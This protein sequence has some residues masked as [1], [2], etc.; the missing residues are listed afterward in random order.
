[1]SKLF[2]LTLRDTPTEAGTTGHQFLLRAGLLRPLG[3]G[4]YGFTPLG[5]QTRRKIKAIARQ[6]MLAV[7]GQ[8]VNLPHVQSADLVNANLDLEKGATSLAGPAAHFRDRMQHEVILSTSQEAAILN[9][10]RGVVQS[11]RQLPL[12]LYQVWTPFRDESRAWGGLFGTRE[13]LVVDG[14]SLHADDAGLDD[15][16]PRV[17]EALGEVFERCQL[18]VLSVMAGRDGDTP[19]MHR[20]VWPS[21][22]GEETVILCDAC[23]YSA[24][25]S[26]AR[27]GKTPP[28]EEDM[29]PMQDIE[30]PECKTI[31]ELAQFLNVPESRT[32][33]ALFL[34]AYIEG[35][36]D[37]FV[38][39]VV[40]GD[41]DLNESKLKRVLNAETVGPATEAEIRHA[42]AEPGYGSPVGLEGVTVVVDD[43]IP[44]SRNLVAGANKPGYH[45]LNVNYGRDYQASSVADITL[46]QAG[47][48]CPECG[49]AL[50][51]EKG[52]ELASTLK[53][54]DRL[55]Q[56][57]D[58]T[59]LD[60]QGKAQPIV[61]G[62]YRLYADRLLAAV[63]ETHYDEHGII[64]PEAI[65][66]YHVYLMTLGKR[67]EKVDTA[68]DRLYSELGAAGI[69]VLYDDRGERAGVKFNDADLLGMPLRVA[70][71]E[72]GLK[73]GTV[74]L[75]QRRQ[76]EVE[77]VAV[78]DL[79]QR[80]LD[81]F[82]NK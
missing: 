60:H 72:R 81:Y 30:T 78:E 19:T 64:W 28:P 17:H 73:N 75:K 8:E 3:F 58:A 33:K 68:A 21:E 71:G 42:G 55:S 80:V 23:G 47:D 43:L 35:E 11:Y 26:I 59:Y 74:E 69:D 34:V 4:S 79:V 5:A 57:T 9:V 70:V 44:E 51:V 67:S 7:G 39:V 29:L 49:S 61:I 14:Y 25:Q 77:V 1:M 10:A 65:A 46:A 15:F 52:I 18:S 2:V 24:D 63:A 56:A 45:T 20:L 54:S 27:A 31:A 22:L 82:A 50:R 41:T 66:P 32:A 37:R 38:F 6:A 13:T 12:M 76:S 48:P 53:M 16:H 62:R 36:G 40:R